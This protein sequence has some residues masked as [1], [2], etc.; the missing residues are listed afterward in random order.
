MF[1]DV[2]NCVFSF[3]F[4]LIGCI[5]IKVIRLLVKYWRLCGILVDG[6]VFDIF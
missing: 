4:L 6:W 2:V 1:R 3:G 5:F